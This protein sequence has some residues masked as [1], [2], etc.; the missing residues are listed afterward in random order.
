MGNRAL[1]LHMD[2]RWTDIQ[3][4]RQNYKLKHIA[5]YLIF[6]RLTFDHFH[7]VVI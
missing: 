7:Y 1:D 2:R 6:A 4:E 5:I 3:L